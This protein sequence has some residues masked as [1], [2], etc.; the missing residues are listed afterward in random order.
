MNVLVV[1]IPASG[2]LNPMLPLV[3]AFVAQGDSVVVASGADM[4]GAAQAHGARFHEACASE[5]A[6]FERL[7]AR[8]RGA[9]GDGL[10]ADRINHYFVPRLFAE[11]GADD[12]ADG[13]IAACHEHRP[14]L[15]V[16]ETYA[17][18]APLAAEVAGVPA[19]HHNIGPLLDPEVLQLCADAASPLWRAL[20]RPGCP[21]DAGVY[22]GATIE[23]TP[24]SLEGR[25]VP[26]GDVIAI[27]PAPLPAAMAARDGRPLVYL[28]LGTVLNT[29]TDVFRAVIDGLADEPVDVI[30]TVG[31][32]GDP[33]VLGSVPPNTRVERY[34][35]QETLLPRCT[36]VVHHG[37]AGTMF[38]A[39]AHGLPQLVLP[40]G[41]DNYVNGALL[42]QAGAGAWLEPDAVQPERIRHEVRVLLDSPER[43]AAAERCA[44]EMAAMA[45]PEEVARELGARYGDRDG[46]AGPGRAGPETT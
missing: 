7:G 20:G 17:F 1:S 38:G 15:M 39:L 35:P 23:I 26:R 9:P 13:V 28:T 34:I 46:G 44:T 43:R 41:A 30:V 29:A 3:D 11:I 36:V 27:R 25:A 21:P 10:P 18:A 5:M 16:Y 24:P 31:S 14:H 4:A 6:W 12:M 2:H 19:V 37:G 45:P 32:N 22:D 33:A 8:T 42:A 40:Q